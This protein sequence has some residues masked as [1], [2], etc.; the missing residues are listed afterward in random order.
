MRIGIFGGTFDP[1]HKGHIQLAKAAKEQLEL[2][3]LILVP[4]HRNP[5]KK[6][7]SV[8]TAKQRLEMV[9]LAIG[10]EPGIVA[11]DIEIAR[12]GVSYTIDTLFELQQAIPGEYWLILGGDTARGFESWKDWQKIASRCRLGVVVRPPET[13]QSMMM[14][15][16]P[17]LREKIDRIDAPPMDISSSAIRADL[18]RGERSLSSLPTKVLQYIL[19]NKLYIEKR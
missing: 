14:R 13:W 3:E 7:R 18:A 12:G 17:N 2:D 1:P 10:N 11:S 16:T 9:K 6:L 8:A 15:V 5:L 19:E 4:A